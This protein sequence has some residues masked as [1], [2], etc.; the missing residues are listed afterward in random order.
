M[1]TY[2]ER[3]GGAWDRGSADS[4]YGRPPIPH[5]FVGATNRS[6]RV[7]MDQMSQE[8]IDAYWAGFDENEKAGNHKDW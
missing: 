3:H 4:Y 6:E 1:T 2:D 7:E 5:F 8:E